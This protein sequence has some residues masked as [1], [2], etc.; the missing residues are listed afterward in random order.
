[1]KKVG[2]TTRPFKY[3]LNQIPYDN[4]VEVRN[5]F[6]GLDLIDRELDDLWM[7]VHD[8]VQET[9]IKTM[10]MEK[11]WKNAKWLSEEAL[12]IAVKRREAKSKG[13]KERYSHLN[14]EL[15]RIARRDKK[16]F[17]SNKYNEENNRMGKTRDLFKKTRDTK[18]TFK[19]ISPRCS[20]EGLMLKLK[21]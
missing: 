7:E 5:R 11:K 4:R 19:E 3:D 13:E 1:M 12:Q 8:I 14:A 10:P 21:L 20:L 9:G 15:Q 17:L 18:G 2:K 6:K 16:A